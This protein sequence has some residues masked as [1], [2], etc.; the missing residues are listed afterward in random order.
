MI[1]RNQLVTYIDDT[2]M[3]DYDSFVKAGEQYRTDATYVNSTMDHFEERANSLK[4]VVLVMKQSV[5]VSYTHLRWNVLIFLRPWS[6]SQT[7]H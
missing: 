7:P 4:E 2:I 6:G 3:P 5:A 1:M